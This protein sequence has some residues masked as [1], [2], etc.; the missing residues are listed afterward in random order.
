MMSFR[1]S[2]F[3]LCFA[4]SLSL[5]ACGDDDSAMDSGA[6]DGGVD[7]SPD[8][9]A[10]DTSVPDTSAPDT[11]VP[12]ATVPGDSFD[13]A[14]AIAVDA[15]ATMEAI[16]APGDVDYYTFEGTEGQWLAILTSA[17]P[18]DD[19]AMLDTVITL[20]DS[21]RA[22][23][24]ENDDGVPRINTDSELITRL[25]ATGTYYIEVQEFS[26]WEG[27]DEP[28]GQP[29]F[30]Y[31]LSIVEIDPAAAAVTIDAEAGDDAATAPTFAWTAA[32]RSQLILGTYR[33]DADV[34]VLGFAVDG[35]RLSLNVN[36]MPQGDEG[37]GS[38]TPTGDVW[39]TT[40]DAPEVIIA[41]VDG[42]GELSLSPS[43][44][45]GDYLLWV[46]HPGAAG[47]NDF[48]VLKATLGEGNT[49]ETEVRGAGT[50]DTLATAEAIALTDNGEGTL[51]GFILSIL[52]T[53][54]V[55]YRSFDVAA[56][57]EVTIV[58]ASARGGSGVQGLTASLHDDTDTLRPDATGVET[59]TD[60]IRI[61]ETSPPA[62]TYYL[63]LE[64]TGQDADVIGD[65][66]RCGIF[67]GPPEL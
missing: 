60:A 15:E 3:T 64:K 31:E 46:D 52:E 50:N 63:R 66:A 1:L 38:T 23:I 19:D 2:S 67:V 54:D 20:Y 34:D 24:A 26:T 30:E 9:S 10:P 29:D 55:D 17:N 32:P 49:L 4:L 43:L 8:T 41:R 11:S 62:G 25:P 59:A 14:V 47:S 35:E 21:S 12:D 33:D 27:S 22:R 45:A 44:E 58:C 6:L 5:L 13:T 57:Q 36:I 16:E 18:D 65:W 48:Y 42:G 56:D 51:N 53:D 37:Y 28:E 40:V 39:I 61:V 7:A